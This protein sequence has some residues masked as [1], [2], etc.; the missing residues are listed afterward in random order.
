MEFSKTETDFRC[1]CRMFTLLANGPVDSF[2]TLE[3]SRKKRK[4]FLRLTDFSPPSPQG[5]QAL[6]CQ[7]LTRGFPVEF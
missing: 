1:N 2:E 7:R 6:F 5:I 3:E 4:I